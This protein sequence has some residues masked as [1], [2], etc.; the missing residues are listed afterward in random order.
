M[1]SST[2]CSQQN[3]WD[4]TPAVPPSHPSPYPQLSTPPSGTGSL[5]H[6]MISLRLSAIPLEAACRAVL[7]PPSY[8]PVF[9]WAPQAQFKRR[10]SMCVLVCIL[11]PKDRGQV[12]TKKAESHSRSVG[13]RF[14]KQGNCQDSS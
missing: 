12:E 6:G 4:Q 7:R 1:Q 8:K 2:S 11:A 5:P 9:R 13:G 14:H 3:T 10:L